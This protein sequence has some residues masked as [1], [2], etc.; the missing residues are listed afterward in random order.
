MK[1]NLFVSDS[2]TRSDEEKKGMAGYLPQGTLLIASILL[3]TKFLMC[4]VLSVN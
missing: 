3:E 1:E 4:R 2:L